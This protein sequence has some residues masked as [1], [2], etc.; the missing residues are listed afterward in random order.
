MSIENLL[1]QGYQSNIEPYGNA[2]MRAQEFKAKQQANALMQMQAQD[3]HAQRALAL[4][5][6]QAAQQAQQQRDAELGR[7]QG[8]GQFDPVAL[9]RIGV[10]KDQ[11][12]F[13]ANRGNLGRP[14]V[15]R[16]AERAGANG[17]PEKVF[18][19]KYGNPVGQALPQ[20]VKLSLENLGGSSVAV[21]PY[22]LKPGQTMQRT[23]TPEGRDA[24]ARG[25]AGLKQTEA[26]FQAGQNAP[27]W[28]GTNMVWVDPKAR[29]VTPATGPDGKPLPA[30]AGAATED[31]RKSAGYAVRMEDALRTLATVEKTNPKATNPG[32]GVSLTNMLPEGVANY[33]RPEDR[34]RVEA[35]QLD[36]LDAALTLAT[37]AAYTKEQ[38]KGL[39]RA[40]FAQP[41][42]LET[43]KAEKAQRLKTVVETARVRAGRA[44][45]T[46]DP[47]LGR[48]GPNAPSKAGALA[49]GAV[50]D[51]Y[52]FKGGNPADK[53]NWEKQ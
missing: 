47:I 9:L 30:K 44:E 10:P 27:K 31:E 29:T 36:A 37:G 49:A 33:I 11:I 25:W 13:L 41:G 21:D 52:R 19:D 2:L 5:Q 24:S 17:R 3:M 39:A 53:A 12:E 14:E 6:A 35:A 7:L 16:E 50:V 15:A 4:Q 1:A 8:G 48:T 51:G 26:H 22:A 32:V 42:D 23:M 18:F 45:P 43:T 40:Y 38:L 20:A 34:Q 28:D 46:I